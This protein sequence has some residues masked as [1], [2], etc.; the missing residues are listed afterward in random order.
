MGLYLEHRAPP[1]GTKLD[2]LLAHGAEVGGITA[3][4]P[5]VDEDRRVLVAFTLN[6]FE[7][8]ALMFEQREVKR[9]LAGRPDVRW[10]R[11]PLSALT[12]QEQS[13]ISPV[14]R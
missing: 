9:Y 10:F 13:Y 1:D 4:S 6:P 3:H 14:R 5:N 2:W 7:A 12:P 11:I 8:A